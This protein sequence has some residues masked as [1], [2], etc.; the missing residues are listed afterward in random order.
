MSVTSWPFQRWLRKPGFRNGRLPRL[1]ALLRGL[2]I[3]NSLPLSVYVLRFRPLNLLTALFSVAFAT[4][5]I[6]CQWGFRDALFES[7]VAIQRLFK[8]D[9]V[10][11]HS[12]SV[13]T[14][15]WMTTFPRAQLDELRGDP[16]VTHTAEAR[17]TYMRWS[18]SGDPT[19][20]LL[21][22]VGVNPNEPALL[23]GDLASHLDL[24]AIPGQILFD[25]RARP[26]YGDIGSLI[27]AKDIPL[28]ML[29]NSRVSIAGTIDIGASF[30]A[31]ATAVMGRETLETIMP[32][33]N[34]GEVEIG[35]IK[36]K[37]PQQR[38]AFVRSVSSSLPPGIRLLT[39]EKFAQME[40]E[41]WDRSKPIG[42][43]F[44]FGVTMSLFI[45]GAILFLVLNTIILIHSGDFATLMALGY[46]RAR[47]QWSVFNQSLLLSLCGYPLGFA[48][49]EVLYG[50]TRRFTNL[51][52]ST[53]LERSMIVFLFILLT[54][55]TSGLLTLQRLNETHPSDA[56]A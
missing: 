21:T 25:R 44:L 9:V 47:L 40:Q 45:G 53:D 41:F 36:L 51:P 23:R 54:S 43:I 26:E 8:A 17:I 34:S 19:A 56:F 18:R 5:M 50:V 2:P 48:L 37:D 38:E 11:I 4:A 42:F 10:M 49:A 15:T 14:L 7:S 35:L 29:E 20:R 13:S 24:L 52:V 1:K 12:A 46:S 28:A 6:L 55:S 16:R 27:Q 22:A 33:M 30:G 3:G 31:D 32:S 39:P